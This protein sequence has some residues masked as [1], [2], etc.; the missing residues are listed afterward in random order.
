MK[1]LRKTISFLLCFC[2]CIGLLP[3][4]FAEEPAIEDVL[5]WENEEAALEANVTKPTITTQPKNISAVDGTQA[6]FTITASGTGLSYQWQYRTSST[7]SWT[8]STAASGK[9]KSFIV[10]ARTAINGYQYRCKVTNAGGSVTSS[11][12]TLTVLTKPAITTQ[13]KNVTAAD[14][15]TATFTVTATGGDLSYQWQYRKSASGTWTNST[16]ASGKTKSYTVNA[17]TAIN[18]YQYRCRIT[19]A[20]GSA[21]SSVVTLTVSSSAVTKPTITKQPAN[22]SAPDGTQTTVSV[23]ATGSNLKYQWQY[24]KNSSSAW[25]NSSA[26]SAN[27]KTLTVNA[28]TAINGY[29]YRCIVPNS[30]GS[31]TSSVATLTV[32]AAVAQPTITTQPKNVTAADGTTAKFTIAASGTGLSYQWQYRKNSSSAWTNSAAASGTTKTFSVNARTAI[33]GYQYRCKVT[34]AGGTVTSSIVTL[35]VVTKPTITTQPKNVTAADGTTAKFTIA[36]SGT[37]LSY[38]W[39][40]RKNSSSAW[41]NSAAASGTTK[42]FSVNARTAI[43]GYQYRCKVTNAGGTVTSSIVTLTVVT[44]PTITTQPKNVT[45]ADGTTAKFTIAASGTGLKYQ[46]QYRTL[47]SGTWTNSTAASGTTATF[48]VNARTAIDGYQ[49]RCKVTN[50]GGTVTSSV[51]T[52]TVTASAAVAINSTNFPDAKFRSFV[53]GHYDTNS[54]GKLSAAEI[55][56]VTSIDCSEKGI[57]SLKGVE[58]FTG[59][60]YLY[61]WNNDLTSLDVSKNTA[62][63]VLKCGDNDLTSLDVSKNTALTELDCYSCGLT[64]LDVSKNTRLTDL[65]C[66][67]NRLTSLNVSGC[68]ALKELSC[69][70]NGMTSLNVSGCTALN[71]LYCESNELTSL[72]VSGCTALTR[73]DCGANMLSELDL[74]KNTELEWLRCTGNEE[75]TTLDVRQCQKLTDGNIYCDGGVTIIR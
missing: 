52:L 75:L 2:L 41:T 31:V 23:T 48:N 67:L 68:T 57:A 1:L 16:A 8:N 15:T 9:T 38:Q 26:A 37:G 55:E 63:I 72:D 5:T 19:N 14:G 22:F 54:D 40:Y 18:G 10:N 20:A 13:P 27:T 65:S 7:A 28:R 44:K 66:T 3:A 39:Q 17:R 56:A 62:L 36:A 64:S 12:V 4:A 49:Y 47:T 35:T 71:L 73:L 51:V 74:S 33:N 32:T 60:K 46:W 30:A 43:N 24:R 69:S 61:C 45:A 53:S 6:T 70:Q 42:T 34:N 21:T 50:A 11:I 58:H 25:T 29:Q 59:L